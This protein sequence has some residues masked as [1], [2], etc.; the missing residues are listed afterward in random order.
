MPIRNGKP[1]KPQELFKPKPVMSHPA[2]HARNSAN[3]AR[4]STNDSRSSAIIG[5]GKCTNVTAQRKNYNATL[6]ATRF[7]PNTN[8]GNVKCDL[9]SNLLRETGLR[10][11]VTVEKLTTKYDNYSSFKISC[12][13]D[14]T[15]VFMNTN[16]WPAGILVRW[17]RNRSN[18]NNERYQ[19][20]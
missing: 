8:V 5:T 1:V 16:I 2:N 18:N 19:R 4:S 6:F 13:C 10:H 11:V 17:W 12:Q 3:N 7:D 9:E 15:A 20:Y 14:N